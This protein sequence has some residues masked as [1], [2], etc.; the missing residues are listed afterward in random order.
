MRVFTLG[1]FPTGLQ[2]EHG[3]FS[4]SGHSQLK[5]IDYLLSVDRNCSFASISK[6]ISSGKSTKASDPEHSIFK[7]K[8]NSEEIPVL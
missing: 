6:E 5:C 3:Y 2:S 1:Y 7:I 8:L 4:K